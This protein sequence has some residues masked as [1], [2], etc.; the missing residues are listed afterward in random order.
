VSAGE[1][2]DTQ[3]ARM[4]GNWER[5]AEGWGRQAERTR[6]IGMPVSSWMIEHAALQPGMRVLELAAGPGDTG[7]LAAELIQ[8]GGTLISSDGAEAMVEVAR[9]RAAELG[10]TNAEFT[11]LE[12]EWIDLET[13]TVDV[14]L[15][16]WGVM[17]SVDPG[18]VLHEIRRVVRPGGRT[19]IA[20]WDE[21][22][23]N[24]WAT[25]PTDVLVERGLAERPP[26]S[27]PGMFALAA[28]GRLQEAL[29]DAGFIEVMVEAIPLP[30][31][32]A[33]AEEFVAEIRDL[34]VAFGEALAGVS[35]DVRTEVTAAIGER[36]E[37]YRDET[38]EGFMLP[39]S[40][41][42]AAAAA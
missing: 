11:P 34:S 29:E 24:P 12:L 42:G 35:E 33:G 13:A 10:I 26:P 7:F 39:G 21:A 28:P 30:R 3:R 41:L 25:I 15:C 22:A 31:R 1:D 19:A 40:S 23:A 5:A 36:L 8:P 18:A 16:R 20:V 6:R 17:L 4:R 32:Y 38:G 2:P 14:V 27:G 37:P 9:R